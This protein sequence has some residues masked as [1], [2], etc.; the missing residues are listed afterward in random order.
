MNDARLRAWIGEWAELWGVPTLPDDVDLSFSPRLT[1]SLGRCHP[2]A[3]RVTLSAD[4]RSRR[5]KLLREV[6]CHEVAHVAVHRLRGP[7]AAPHG[8]EWRELVTMAGFE[9]RTRAIRP[10]LRLKGSPTPT[11]LEYEHR[12]PVCHAVRFARRPSLWSAP[13]FL[14]AT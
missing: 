8:P 2:A 11:K 6:L 12:C 13:F 3:G 10:H 9:P 7:E 14:L 5:P 4:L 1:A